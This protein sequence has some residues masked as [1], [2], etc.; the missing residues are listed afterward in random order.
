MIYICDNR[1]HLICKPYSI[2]NLHRM[3][4]DIGLKRCWFHNKEGLEHYDIPKRRIEEIKS[5]CKVV[6]SKEIVRII[7][8]SQKN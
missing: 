6:E 7:K 5:I 2:D 1:R 4:E 3:A 8:S